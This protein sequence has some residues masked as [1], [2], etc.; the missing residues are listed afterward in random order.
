MKWFIYACIA[1]FVLIAQAVFWVL[2]ARYVAKIPSAE[3]EIGLG[4][5]LFSLT[6][7]RYYYRINIIPFLLVRMDEG[8]LRSTWQIPM[9]AAL[10][11]LTLATIFLGVGAI[12]AHIG[13]L[14]ASVNRT[15]NLHLLVV[16]LGVGTSLFFSMINV[17]MLFLP[18]WGSLAAILILLRIDAASH[19][20]SFID[21][22]LRWF[23]N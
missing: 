4:P 17:F 7:N 5:E 16:Q 22:V 1:P 11:H 15:P 2:A 8:S 21:G 20:T 14:V 9:F 10:A 6:L 3:V 12:C 23:S 13:T 19:I 18:R